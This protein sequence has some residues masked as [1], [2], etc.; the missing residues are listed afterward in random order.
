MFSTKAI[1]VKLAYRHDVDA[2]SLLM[3]RMLFALPLFLVLGI[4][5][6]TSTEGGSEIIKRYKWRL[7]G[8]GLLG[9]YIASYF[10][11]KGLEL[12]DASLERMILFL[13]P[14]VVVF[15]SF[16]IYK[17]QIKRSQVI[18]I[19]IGYLGMYL[20]FQGNA[21]SHASKSVLEGSLLVLISTIT[22]S[23]YLVGTGE[24]SKKLGSVI[25]NS[26]TMTIA[27]LA[28][29]IHNTIFHGFNL[30]DFTPPVYL[31]ALAISIISTVI[32]SYLIVEG[33]RIVGANHSSILGFVGPVSTI[34]LAIVILGEQIS[35]VQ[36]VGSMVVFGA[37]VFTV[38]QKD[39]PAQSS[40]TKDE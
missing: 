26:I 38:I 8:L 22:Y 28:I 30:F 7:I 39:N 3:L 31:Y 6:N 11:L 33:I 14:T 2:L 37:V 13:Y 23:L 34:I 10:D 29:I 25:Y 9:Y 4:W 16:L 27:A 20:V 15:L 12:I 36:A 32:P 1:F 35:A 21:G 24:L 17:V 5:Q 18:A 19:C 40:S